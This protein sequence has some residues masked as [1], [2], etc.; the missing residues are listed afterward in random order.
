MQDSTPVIMNFQGKQKVD[1]VEL[2]VFEMVRFHTNFLI[3]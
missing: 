1:F 3:L 2:V